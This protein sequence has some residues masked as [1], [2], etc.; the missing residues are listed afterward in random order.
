MDSEYPEFDAGP[1]PE[2]HPCGVCGRKFN[3]SSLQRHQAV[4]AKSQKNAARRGVFD[5]SK[6]RTAEL[7]VK[8]K[9]TSKANSAAIERAAQETQLEGKA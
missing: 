4:C 7:E 1:P 8:P 5:P 2:L 6:K 3:P 9:K